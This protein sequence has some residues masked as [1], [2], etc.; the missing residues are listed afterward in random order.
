MAEVGGAV[1]LARVVPGAAD[2][3]LRITAPDGTMIERVVSADDEGVLAYDFVPDLPGRHVVTWATAD[4]R[5][6][7][8]DVVNV[9]SPEWHA[10]IGLPETKRHLGIPAD[11][12]TDDG[13]L[14]SVILT[15]SAVA[16]DVVGVVARRTVTEYATG[17]GRHVV[18]ERPP[19][20]DVLEV[21]AH[22][23]PVDPGEYT[24]SQSGLV[25]HRSSW[26]TGLRGIEVTYLAGRA[27]VPANI[28]E[29]VL[30][31]VRVNW[32]PRQGGNY[33]AFDGGRGDHFGN[34]GLEASLQGNLRLGF[35]VPNAVTQRLQPDQRGPVVL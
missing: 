31:L 18:L 25:S 17:G 5:T 12:T 32:R 7:Y 9:V 19:I 14:R 3:T 4:P 21:R 29:A 24:A 11:D 1:R 28:A 30:E 10:I 6:A 23:V 16:E 22:G 20:L 13:D 15:A 26:P 34:A 33:S 2:G 8:A 27:I 35:F